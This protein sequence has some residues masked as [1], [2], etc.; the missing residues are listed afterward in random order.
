MRLICIA[1]LALSL[2]SSVSGKMFG[3][4]SGQTSGAPVRNDAAPA[5]A[6]EAPPAAAT[7]KKSGGAAGTTPRRHK[8]PVMSSSASGD[9]SPRKTVVREGGASEPTA[10][11]VPGITPEEAAH[12]RQ[13][14]EQLLSSTD[15]QLKQLGGRTLDVPQQQTVGQVRNYMADARSALQ[16]GDVRRASTLA[17]K[18]YLLAE[19]LMKH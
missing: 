16:E 15:L 8:R 6:K 5:P 7:V 9:G 14:A 3:Q 4:M 10:Q 17:E 13:N 1:A 12:H 19:D 11:I 18:A 2:S